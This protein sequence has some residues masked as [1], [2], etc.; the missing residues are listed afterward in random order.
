MDWSVDAAVAALGWL[1]HEDA[2]TRGDV[3]TVFGEL[4]EA[5]P[6]PGHVGY[7]LPLVTSWSRVPDVSPALR[8]KLDALRAELE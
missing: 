1:A 6:R 7:L 8:A 4:F 3:L 5:V 2:R